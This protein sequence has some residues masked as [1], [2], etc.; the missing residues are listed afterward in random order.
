MGGFGAAHL[1]F[2]F[3]ELFGTVIVNSG[4]LRDATWFP[5]EE[6]PKNLA[7]KNADKLRHQTHIHIGCGS[8]DDLLPANQ[9]L[10]DVLQQLG[11]D[12]EYEVVPDVAHNP[13]LYYQK[14]GTK[15]F[16]FHRAAL[17]ALNKAQP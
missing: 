17:A 1:G 4:A 16:E 11:V 10:H 5:A 12:N 3:P 15:H 2:K 8:L 9:E 13:P 14:L 7:R 6:H